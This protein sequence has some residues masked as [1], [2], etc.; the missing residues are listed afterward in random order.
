MGA[1]AIIL[2]AGKGTRFGGDKVWSILAG[3]PVWRWSFETFLSHPGIEAVGIVGAEDRLDQFRQL[4]PEAA[5][6]V[7]GGET[8]TES[9]RIGVLT[10]KS[11]AVLLHD[12]A[13]P[14]VSAD[15]IQAVL[16]AIERTG[17]GAPGVP[18]SDT[19]RTVRSDGLE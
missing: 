13:R 11:D 12:A 16:D 14:Y 4:A 19:V 2:A 1:V 3:K 9:S 15:V 7:A 6:I 5:F 10:A 17:A 8:R 18:I